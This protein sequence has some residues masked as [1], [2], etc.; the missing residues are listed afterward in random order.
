MGKFADRA[1][2]ALCGALMIG[3]VH[4]CLGG[5]H[6][7]SPLEGRSGVQQNVRVWM[8]APEEHMHQ[9]NRGYVTLPALTH[10]IAAVTTSSSAFLAA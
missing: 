10:E 6:S 3:L 1:K 7:F 8:K 9:D 4:E 2:C 5:L